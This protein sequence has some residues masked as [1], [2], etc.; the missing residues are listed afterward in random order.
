MHRIPGRI[1]QAVGLMLWVSACEPG[2]EPDEADAEELSQELIVTT[3]DNFGDRDASDWSIF[4][5][6]A[7]SITR[8]VVRMGSGYGYAMK[9]RYQLSSGG[10]GGVEK[11][12]SAPLATQ[13][14]DGL[15]VMVYGTATGHPLRIQVYDE[16][17]EQWQSD[18]NVTWNGWREVIIR[19]AQFTLC[20]WQPASAVR[21]G[22]KDF[23]RLTGM[24]LSPSM[25]PGTSG[26]LTVDRIALVSSG[27]A[28][29]PSC[30]G[31]TCGSSDGC[32]GTCASGSGC[33][34]TSQP[35]TCSPSCTGTTCG[36]PDGCGGTCTSGSGCTVPGGAEP[37][38][39]S[40]SLTPS[41]ENFL[42]PERGFYDHVNLAGTSGFGYVRTNGRSVAMAHVHLDNYRTRDLDAT[43]LSA[44]QAGFDRVRAA[45]IKVILRF[46]YN[47]C[48]GC[49]DASKA[50]ILRHIQ[51]LTPLLQK[52]ADVIL[53]FQAGFI[54]AWGE[55]HSSTNGLD[56][57][58]DRKDILTAMLAALPASRT[59][60]VRAPNYKLD[61]FGGPLADS[62]AFSGTDA[63][64][65]G[66]FNDCFLASNTDYGTYSDSRRTI[67]G[68]KSFIAQET[69]FTPMGGETCAVY[70]PRTDCPSA[71]AEMARLHWSFLNSAYNQSVLSTWS[72]QG[73]MGSVQR[74]LGYR[75]SLVQASFSSAVKPGGVLRLEATVRNSGYAALFN[76]RPVYAVLSSGSTRLAAKL[77]IDPRRWEPGQDSSFTTQLR[78]PANLAA[79]TYRL[80]LWLPDAASTLEA[81][82]EYAVRFAN[83]GIW[84]AAQGDNQLTASLPI[85]PSVSG[86]ADPGATQ[87]VEIP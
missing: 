30:T 73:C 70:S 53:T 37:S 19:F 33:T 38:L 49:A 23:Q 71:T 39:T 47:E 31:K 27:S 43:Y 50:Q 16:G 13:G 32:G 83:A 36:S 6:G 56:N 79:G 84:D 72:S 17:G 48:M 34:T 78:V 82:P 85:D 62:A 86:S 41:T 3:L 64:R 12:F 22:V 1:F 69:R 2:L 20:S 60:Q 66:H 10:Y 4:R 21:N 28:C 14:A 59:I 76:A 81:V 67:D 77:S 65:T 52:N 5:D 63:A 35:P 74:N 44:L 24:A 42:N 87:F 11:F 7:S 26:T 61:A 55:F 68:W 45:K 15:R 25:R 54:G 75:L 80:S 46:S 8:S 58:T 51:Q 18:V 40:V 9:L 57:P 29:T